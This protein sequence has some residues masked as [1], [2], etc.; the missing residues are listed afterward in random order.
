[1]YKQK[2]GF[3]LGFHGCEKSKRDE[4]LLNPSSVPAR[5][6]PYDWLGEGMYFWEFDD[7]HASKWARD[8]VKARDPAVLGAVID[9]GFCLDLTQLDHL[10]LLKEAYAAL[11]DIHAELGIPLP[12]N[13]GGLYKKKRELDCAVINLLHLTRAKK[14]L[15]EFDSVRSPFLEGDPLYPDAIFMDETHIQIAIRNPNCIKGFFL[16]RGKTTEYPDP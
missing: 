4:L 9:L 10:S 15:R 14:G 11:C 7:E 1:M 5:K 3:I 16:P 13:I 2:P 8:V 6:K 12:R